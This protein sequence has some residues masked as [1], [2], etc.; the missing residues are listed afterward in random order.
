[1]P[2]NSSY[3][4]NKRETFDYTSIRDVIAGLPERFNM[5]REHWLKYIDGESI[6]FR[7]YALRDFFVLKCDGTIAPCLKKWDAPCASLEEVDT[8]RGCLN[9]WATQWSW[10]ADGWPYLKYYILHPIKFI[11]KILNG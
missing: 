10:Q 1:M 5:I 11:R 3:Y 6:E 8:C 7:C 4:N 2:E 9:T